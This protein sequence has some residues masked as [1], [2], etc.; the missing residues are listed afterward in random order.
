MTE[1]SKA[2]VLKAGVS[3]QTVKHLPET[4]QASVTW[5][6]EDL[7]FDAESS[8]RVLQ[9]GTAEV[10]AWS[11]VTV[12]ESG[13]SQPNPRKVTIPAA[14]NVV[15]GDVLEIVSPSGEH[16][17]FEVSGKTSGEYALAKHRL[18]ATY[19]DG[20]TVRPVLLETA[21]IA[22]EHVNDD[23]RIDG[24]EPLQVVWTYPNG[25]RF[26]QQ[27]RVVR[28]DLGELDVAE[29]ERRILRLFPD[30]KTRLEHHDRGD[31]IVDFIKAARDDMHADM[32]DKHIDHRQFMTGE[33][34]VSALVWWTLNHL[35]HLGNIPANVEVDRYLDYT[36]KNA[37]RFFLKLT[38]GDAGTDTVEL[39]RT[40]DA[41][42]A[43][44]GGIYRRTIEEL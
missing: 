2:G 17:L 40:S 12:G 13:P 5:S 9:S 11:Y 28:V 43:T 44:E 23:T 15:V 41:A 4:Q 10:A 22:D 33:Q 18:M 8:E 16:E 21:A 39:D 32:M 29:I 26:R 1:R 7:M 37:K 36:E 38:I 31:T 34:G 27:V 14:A 30:I 19:P 20:S 25:L 42:T 3:G 24:H 6:L 35:G